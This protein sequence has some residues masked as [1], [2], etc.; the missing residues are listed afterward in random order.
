MVPTHT[1]R[2]RTKRYRYYVCLNAQKRGWHTCPS[3]SIPA[4][5]IERFVLEQV[6]CIGRDP[7]LVAETLEAARA[8]AQHRT[9]ELTRER[10]GLERELGRNHAEL[11]NLADGP[12]ASGAVTGRMADLQDRIRLAEQR[13]TAVEEELVALGRNEVD[14]EDAARALSV[15]DPVWD[16]LCV[17]EQIRVI[18][19]LVERVD[20]D[21]DRG[22]VSVT[23][24]PA[25][26]D[27]L[28]RE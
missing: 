7:T 11:R 4:Q 28:G 22:T 18:Q 25:G 23:F 27:A 15:F 2:N 3:K 17:R 24:H 10:R 13:A 19:L 16:S 6:R 20:Y 26:I 5:E 1:T 14:A 9:E 8:E 12:T 21:G